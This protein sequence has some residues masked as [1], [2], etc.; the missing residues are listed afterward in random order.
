M[1]VPETPIRTMIKLQVSETIYG[2]SR[3]LPTRGRHARGKL[4]GWS[5]NLR[6]S[7]EKKVDRFS[8][9]LHS[10]CD[11][12]LKTLLSCLRD[13]SGLLLPKGLVYNKHEF[14]AQKTIQEETH[15]TPEAKVLCAVQLGPDILQTL[16]R[17]D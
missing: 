4:L 1:H 6:P 10:T 17:N 8:Y 14:L 16:G 7:F 2:C 12:T 15:I 11:P 13:Y 3:S 5:R 9:G